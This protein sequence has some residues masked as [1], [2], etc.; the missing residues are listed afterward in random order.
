MSACRSLLLGNTF[1]RVHRSFVV[2]KDKIDKLERHQGTVCGHAVPVGASY[3]PQ[4]KV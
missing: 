1:V 2:A 3:L 4:L